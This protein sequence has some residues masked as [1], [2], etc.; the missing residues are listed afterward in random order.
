MAESSF[1]AKSAAI[2]PCPA[3]GAE[4]ASFRGTRRVSAYILVDTYSKAPTLGRN[5]A[6]FIV[7][8]W[9]SRSPARCLLPESAEFS[10]KLRRDLNTMA[11]A[12]GTR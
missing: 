7:A 6:V 8:A 4:S 1:D 10:H 11:R 5:I 12:V 2:L 3:H 9:Q